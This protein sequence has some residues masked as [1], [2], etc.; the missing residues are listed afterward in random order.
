MFFC[1][2]KVPK[3]QNTMFFCANKIKAATKDLPESMFILKSRSQI[4]PTK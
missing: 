1:A 4:Q 3:A 2:N